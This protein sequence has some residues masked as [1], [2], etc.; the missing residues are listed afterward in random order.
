MRG[1]NIALISRARSCERA[2]MHPFAL[3]GALGHDK[4]KVGGPNRGF[5]VRQLS[6][7]AHL[8]SIRYTIT[9]FA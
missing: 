4:E 2:G 3:Y 1:I 9:P 7:K 8:G 6:C 5:N